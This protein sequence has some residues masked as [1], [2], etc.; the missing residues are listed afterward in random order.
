MSQAITEQDVR[1]VAKLSRLQLD[2]EQVAHLADQLG[3]VLAYVSKLNELDVEGV[4]PMAHPMDMPNVLRDDIEQ[5]GLSVQQAL[6]NAP[7]KDEP[8]FKVPKVIGEGSG[9]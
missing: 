4:A 9:A 3:A 5:P 6:M 7:A 8:F 1:H 2:G